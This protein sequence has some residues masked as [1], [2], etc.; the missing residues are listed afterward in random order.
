MKG[1]RNVDLDEKSF[2]MLKAIVSKHVANNVTVLIFGS[3]VKRT[4]KQYSGIDICL[5]CDNIILSEVICQLQEAFSLSNLPF[6]VDIVVYQKCTDAFKKI[7]DE[8][9]IKIYPEC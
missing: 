5:K 3:R 2:N 1:Y 9:S 8:N 7:I 4:A 6:R